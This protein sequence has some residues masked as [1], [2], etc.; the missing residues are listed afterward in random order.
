MA[1]INRY[2]IIREDL[3]QDPLTIITEGL[4]IGR[5]SQCELLLNHPSV[6]RV[7]AGIKQ[8]EGVH[9]VFSLRTSNSVILNGKRVEENEAL[10]PGDILTIGPF[11]IAVD[12]TDQA[13]SLEVSLRIGTVASAADVSS[14]E[15]ETADLPAEVE[16]K[17]PAKPRPA[18]IAGNKALDIFWDKRIREA[19][20]MVRPSPFFP[21]SRR[22]AGKAQ[23]NWT[24]T[25][26]LAYRWPIAFFTWAFVMIGLLS[27]VAAYAY[28][29]AYSPAPIAQAHARSEL[30]LFP[31]IAARP[32]A[33]QCTTC[34]SLSGN[35]E[36]RCANCHNADAFVATII[37]P[38]V[39]AGIG[40]NDCHAE[41]RGSEF[42]PAISALGTCTD[43]HNNSNP[44]LFNG[45]R[46]HTPHGGT[47]GYP[48]A[49]GKWIWKGVETEE[50]KLKQIPVERLP[51]ESEN[52]W[53]SKQ[54][55][56]LH[57]YR[58]KAV[59]DME[60]NADG[61]LSCSSCHKAFNPIDSQTPRMTCG[62]CHNGKIEAGSGRPLIASDK[63]NCTSCHVQH[64]RSKRHW[65]RT[66]LAELVFKVSNIASP[67]E[68]KR[69]I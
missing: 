52:E 59:G 24:P 46:V 67:L 18:P 66:L 10:A 37:P 58:V 29:S 1:L 34:H 56:S 54:F 45:V 35:M 62:A 49:D 5:L 25:S 31:T 69:I 50:W 4:L 9:Y 40:C 43:C 27:L 57:V 11:A 64:I 47:F 16:G 12:I 41:H 2:I 51:H 8:I 21:R 63:P 44:R 19:G 55:H 68:I 53:R 39:K 13:L 7:Q 20:K 33:N 28:T 60:R 23:F 3:V 17:K 36:Q 22:R 48:V 65:N 14:P 30:T 6:S 42:R 26:D 38:H 61:Q 15:V 32:N